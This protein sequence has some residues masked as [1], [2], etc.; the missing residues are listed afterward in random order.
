MRE[1]GDRREMRNKKRLENVGDLKRVIIVAGL[2][3]AI[4]GPA[5]KTQPGHVEGPSCLGTGR[6]SSLSPNRNWDTAALPSGRGRLFFGPLAQ[7]G[8]T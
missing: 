8:G 6:A 3:W 1:G 4:N 2:N 5:F 7:R